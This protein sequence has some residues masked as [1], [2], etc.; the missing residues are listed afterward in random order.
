MNTNC[1][2]CG[3]EPWKHSKGVRRTMDECNECG[4]ICEECLR[5]MSI[6][7]ITMEEYEAD[8]LADMHESA[9]FLKRCETTEKTLCPEC[10]EQPNTMQRGAKQ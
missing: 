5:E 3:Y 8:A 1:V 2:K 7:L 10:F 4:V 6:E 9:P